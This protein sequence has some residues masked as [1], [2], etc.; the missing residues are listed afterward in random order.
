M[1]LRRKLEDCEL[2]KK[3]LCGSMKRSAEISGVA[4]SLIASRRK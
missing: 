2:M 1:R 3:L 4:V